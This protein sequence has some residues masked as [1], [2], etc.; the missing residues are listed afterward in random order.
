MMYY[1]KTQK[2]VNAHHN[3]SCSDVGPLESLE[4]RLSRTEN[5]ARCR[6]A[7]VSSN[8]LNNPSAL[9][10]V[11]L[12]I[13][14]LFAIQKTGIENRLVFQIFVPLYFEDIDRPFDPLREST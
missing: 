12:S 8:A 4:L 13:E 14:C 10:R 9:L 5:A 1:R 7:N 3:S 11:R 2:N 6:L